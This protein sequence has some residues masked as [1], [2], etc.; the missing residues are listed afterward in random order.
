MITPEQRER[1]AAHLNEKFGIPI[2]EVDAMLD[3]HGVP[4]LAD[5]CVLGV[6]NPL[7]WF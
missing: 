4:I 3:E 1:L 7:Q 5:D 2:G 6:A